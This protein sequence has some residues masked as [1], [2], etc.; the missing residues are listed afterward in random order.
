M[1]LYFLNV[2]YTS[3]NLRYGV[4]VVGWVVHMCMPVVCS[5]SSINYKARF[6]IEM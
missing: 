5:Y 4:F 6:E 1:M 3:L 2:L